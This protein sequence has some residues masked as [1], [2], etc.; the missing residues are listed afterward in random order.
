MGVMNGYDKKI[1]GL[2]GIFSAPYSRRSFSFH[3][4][5]QDV[6]VSPMRPLPVMKL[7]LGVVANVGNEQGTD[8]VI[9]FTAGFE[10][11]AGDDDG[12]LA[13]KAFFFPGLRLRHFVLKIR[14]K[15]IIYLIKSIVRKCLSK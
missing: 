7:R 8:D 6:L 5:D 11:L 3:A 1:T 13:G 14:I 10:D 2:D 12:F 15:S 9:L 4:V